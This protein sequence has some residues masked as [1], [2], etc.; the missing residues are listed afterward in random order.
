MDLTSSAI[1][2]YNFTR[3]FSNQTIT[4]FQDGIGNSWIP[5][6]LPSL[7]QVS[8]ILIAKVQTGTAATYYDYYSSTGVGVPHYYATSALTHNSGSDEFTETD[9]LGTTA[10]FYG[11]IQTAH[12]PGVLKQ[13][14]DSFGNTTSVAYNNGMATIVRTAASSSFQEEWVYSYIGGGANGGLI[15]TV[16]Y[17]RSTGS[18]FG[19]IIRLAKYTY[20]DGIESFGNQGDLKFV[21][22]EDGADGVSGTHILD[23]KYYRYYT[24]T[25]HVSGYIRGLKYVLGPQSCER[26]KAA[27][28]LSMPTNPSAIFDG[29]SDTIVGAYAD[30]YFEYDSSHRA[31]KEIAQGAGCSCSGSSGQGIYQYSYTANPRSPSNDMNKWSQETTETLPDGNV[32]YVYT[33]YAG[34]VMLQVHRVYVDPSNPGTSTYRDFP[35]FC[36]FDT[37]G[38]LLWKAETSAFHSGTANMSAVVP[39]A[40]WDDTNDDLLGFGISG[41]SSYLWDSLGLVHVYTYGSSTGTLGDG[42]AGN[43][44]DGD[45]AGYS[46]AEYVQ[47]GAVLATGSSN[48]FKVWSQTYYARTAGSMTTYPIASTTVY[49]SPS[50]SGA[51][52]EK[53]TY[54][55][56]WYTGTQ[57]M[58]S[59]TT[60]R[61]IIASGQNGPGGTMG[62]STVEF[63]DQFGNVVWTQDP[64]GYLTYTAYDNAKGGVIE[65]V[66]DADPSLI[67]SPQVTAPTRAGGLPTA[68]NL[69]TIYGVDDLGRTVSATDPR[70]SAATPPAYTT[71]TFYNDPNHEVRVYPQFSSASNTTTGPIQISREDR[72]N[73]YIEN[74]TA[75]AT[76]TLDG[77]NHPNGGETITNTNVQ[78]LTRTWM[79]LSG[80]SI[81]VDRFFHFPSTTYNSG[82]AISYAS[83]PPTVTEWGTKDTDYYRTLS[84]YDVKGRKGRVQDDLG[85]IT[86]TVYDGL[87]RVTQIWMGTDDGNGTWNGTNTGTENLVQL[88]Q[89]IYDDPTFTGTSGTGNGV[90]SESSTY[91]HDTSST[92]RT[93]NMLYDWRDRLVATKNGVSTSEADSAHRPI[94]ISDLD[95]LGEVTV[96]YQYDGDGLTVSVSSAGI[97]TASDSTKLRAETLVSYDDQ[98]RVYQRQTYSVD[99]S[100][101]SLSTNTLTTN[102]FYDHRGNLIAT[103]SPGGVVRKSVYDGAGRVSETYT[104]DGATD[105]GWASALAV[106]GNNILEESIYTYDANGNVTLTTTKSRNHDETATGELGTPTTS[107]KA[108]IAYSAACFDPA[109]RTIAAVAYGT[110]GGSA[111]TIP[112]SAPSSSDTVLVTTTGYN[113]AGWADTINDPKGLI[114][115]TT[116]DAAGRVTQTIEDYTDG[117]PTA[118]TNRKTTYTYDGLDHTLTLT[119]VM[120]SGTNN[121]T[122]QYTYGVT[123]TG[124]AINSNSLLAKVAYPDKTAGTASTSTGDQNSFTYDALGEVVIKTDQNGTLHTYTYDVLGRTTQDAVT[125]A[126]GN[127]NAVDNAVLAI[128]INF[129]TAGRPYQLTSYSNTAGTTAVNQVQCAYNGLGQLTAEYQNHSGTVNTSTTPKTQYA[130]TEMSVG[131]SAVNNSRLKSITYPNGRVVNYLYMNASDINGVSDIIS[132]VTA[133]ATNDTSRGTNDA[134]VIAS[135][136]YLG[137]STIVRKNY[138]TPGVRLDRFGG[139][140][141]TYAGLD[142]FNRVINQEWTGYSVST[143]TNTT[144]GDLFKIGHGYDRD[145]NRLYAD[146]QTQPA[147]PTAMPMTTSTA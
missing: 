105:S 72:A 123:T 18:S 49:R 52:P 45:V 12:R 133:I 44:V 135:Y 79:D 84:G 101:G 97:A 30:N 60:A 121:Q 104:S 28:S 136:D 138:P 37:Q 118:S 32:N 10:I 73:N 11:F 47:Q 145:S 26:L 143:G 50:L 24:P 2:G 58:S 39:S 108:R 147:L 31:T 3:S 100:A 85:D 76:P 53:T 103:Y 94:M 93:A 86:R 130:Y 19:A 23:M 33:N 82:V 91:T 36:R 129:D 99:Q 141:G 6:Q 78:T 113:S 88:S 110:N 134:N 68:L 131:G 35:V 114:T 54:T 64:E 1:G 34:E 27:Q 4:S 119:A 80:C 5:S 116:Y 29:I 42:T 90:L 13:I 122:T 132:R 125:L 67:T 140:S 7:V 92:I 14:T 63:F 9:A 74:L 70:Y 43:T 98:G 69:V 57:Q 62:D 109:N 22:I 115:K 102:T 144:N 89:N 146:N 96:R 128:G 83:N 95:N 120:P 117:T 65:H 112:T 56:A 61:A 126:S 71:Y 124:S 107:P 8:S 55:Y 77:N 38:R 139:T 17:K 46:Q 16:S 21:A 137:L 75:N 59:R 20:Y 87:D 81:V 15:N 106:T 142:Q 66:V 51:S 41:S 40:Y 127:P 111:P 25:D 48:R